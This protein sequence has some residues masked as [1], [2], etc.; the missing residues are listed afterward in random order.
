MFRKVSW[1]IIAAI[2]LSLL[3]VPRGTAQEGTWSE[4]FD[5]PALPGWEHSPGAS[6]VDGVLR[7][8]PGNFAA[9]SGDW[10]DF[11]LA[12][13]FRLPGPGGLALVYHA[14]ESGSHILVLHE[15]NIELHRESGGQTVLLNM[16]VQMDAQGRILIPSLLRESADMQ[17]EVAVIGHLNYLD[18]WNMNR[19]RSHLDDNPL[20]DDDM[21]ALSDLGI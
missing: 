18:V 3:S 4:T 2:W 20:T 11:T 5:D 7:I 17:G 6:V 19:F 12:L 8:E 9:R 1:L 13:S 14:G 15:N 16:A 21:Q 10:A